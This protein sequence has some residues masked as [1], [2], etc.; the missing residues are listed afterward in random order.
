MKLPL[1]P[2]ELALAMASLLTAAAAVWLVSVSMSV[3]PERDPAHVRFWQTVAAALLAFVAA[4]LAYLRPG[5][6]RAFERVSLA[7]LGVIAAGLGLGAVVREA[8]VGRSGG[9]FEGYLLLL[10]AVVAAHGVAALFV[11]LPSPR[12]DEVQRG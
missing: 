3:L 11:A 7:A 1:R 8:G 12:G 4:G 2:V 6:R 5:H 9:H 10:G